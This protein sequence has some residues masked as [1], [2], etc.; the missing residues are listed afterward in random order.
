MPSRNLWPSSLFSLGG[1]A[2]VGLLGLLSFRRDR[3]ARSA[4]GPDEQRRG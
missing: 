2:V 1:A 3:M 4:D